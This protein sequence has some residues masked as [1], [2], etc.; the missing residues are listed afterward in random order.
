[1]FLI[2]SNTA[3]ID[4]KRSTPYLIRLWIIFTATLAKAFTEGCKWFGVQLPLQKLK[5]ANNALQ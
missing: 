4:L 1:M 5:I 2:V 3:S